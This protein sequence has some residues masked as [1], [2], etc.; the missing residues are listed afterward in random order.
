[1]IRFLVFSSLP[2]PAYKISNK[3]RRKLPVRHDKE[4]KPVEV[5]GIAFLNEMNTFINE[6]PETAFFLCNL[7]MQEVMA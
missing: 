6:F 7:K 5:V 3:Y 2:T 1:M 4:V